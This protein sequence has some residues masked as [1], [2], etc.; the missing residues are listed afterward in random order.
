MVNAFQRGRH[1][2]SLDEVVIEALAAGLDAADTLVDIELVELDLVEDLDVT[3][4][5]TRES[6]PYERIEIAPLHEPM[7]FATQAVT[8][9][10]PKLEARVAV[11]HVDAPEWRPESWRWVAVSVTAWAV[12]V[13][14]WLVCAP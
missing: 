8:V 14:A 4:R 13:T 3:A 1:P 11:A 2:R 7:G 12:A 5:F 9:P 10:Y 6:T